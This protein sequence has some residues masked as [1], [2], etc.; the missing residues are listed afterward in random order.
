M[1]IYL[2]I[3]KF[4]TGFRLL[5]S[6]EGG[7]GNAGKIQKG[8]RVVV[9]QAR[10]YPVTSISVTKDVSFLLITVASSENL[11]LFKIIDTFGT[12]TAFR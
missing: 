7:R 4:L 2:N 9:Q 10:Q 11:Y 1:F 3:Q 5:D 12:V 8:C 6:G